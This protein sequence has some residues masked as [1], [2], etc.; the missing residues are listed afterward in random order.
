MRVTIGDRP[1]PNPAPS[2]RGPAAEGSDSAAEVQLESPREAHA[3]GG[4]GVDDEQLI[5]VSNF[6]DAGTDSMT[7]GIPPELIEAWRLQDGRYRLDEQ[8]YEANTGELIVDG[9]TG[10]FSLQLDAFESVVYRVGDSTEL[11]ARGER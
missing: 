1:P 3:L 5:I 4:T 2:R 6:A 7:I 11:T 9:G 8:L 10:Q